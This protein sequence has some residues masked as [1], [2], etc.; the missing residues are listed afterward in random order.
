MTAQAKPTIPELRAELDRVR[1]RLET[2]RRYEA[3][4]QADIDAAEGREHDAALHRAVAAGAPYAETHRLYV[5]A[6]AHDLLRS[7]RAPEETMPPEQA[8]EVRA[9]MERIRAGSESRG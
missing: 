8:Q 7:S 5:I 6:Q 2:L 9:E 1:Y 3:E 4:V